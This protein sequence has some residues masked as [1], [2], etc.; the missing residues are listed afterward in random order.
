V[1]LQKTGFFGAIVMLILFLMA[2][3]FA[4]QQKRTLT[5]RNGAVVI[6]SETSVKS[7]PA[8]NGTDLFR[9]HE[10]TKV[11]IT[12]DSMKDW[13]EIRLPDGKE[14]WMLTKD[15]EVI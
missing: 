3:L 5:M 9:L 14:G 8:Q 1:A 15:M 6:A 7:T 11:E 10:G 4:Y 12:D 13:K 2:N